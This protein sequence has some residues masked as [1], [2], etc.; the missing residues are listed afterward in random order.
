MQLLVSVKALAQS[1]HGFVFC[2]IILRA[3]N[4]LKVTGEVITENRADFQYKD[5]KIAVISGPEHRVSEITILPAASSPGYHFLP[6]I[7][8]VFAECAEE[9]TI[10]YSGVEVNLLLECP[11]TGSFCYQESVL[12]SYVDE[13]V[14]VTAW[15]SDVY[16]LVKDFHGLLPRYFSNA[17]LIL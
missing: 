2:S 3:I 16:C 7:A 4:K 10:G 15:D 12:N 6:K 13:E 1:V 14:M 17:L 8:R 9:I 5:F 11:T